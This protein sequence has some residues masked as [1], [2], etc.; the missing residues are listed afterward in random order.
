MKVYNGAPPCRGHGSSERRLLKAHTGL[1]AA[2]HAPKSLTQ[3]SRGRCTG[4]VDTAQG[5][6]EG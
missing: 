3:H 1:L 2:E 6:L 5:R 4:G